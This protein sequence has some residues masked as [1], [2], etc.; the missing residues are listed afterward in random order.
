MSQSGETGVAWVDVVDNP[1]I[2]FTTL[3]VP[4]PTGELLLNDDA[5]GAPSTEPSVIATTNW[6]NLVAFRDQRSDGGDIYLQSVNNA[7]LLDEVNQRVDQDS[8]SA[9]QSEPSLAVSGSQALIVWVDS[10]DMPGQSGQRVLGRFSSLGGQMSGDEFAISESGQLAVKRSPVAVMNVSGFGLVVWLDERGGLAQVYGK[11]LD[12]NGVPSGTELLFSNPAVDLQIVDLRVDIDG[13]DN[14]YLLWLDSGGASSVVRM[15]SFRPDHSALSSFDWSPPL[16]GVSLLEATARVMTSEEVMVAWIGSDGFSRNLYLSQLSVTGTELTAP[17]LIDDNAN[18]AP[19]RPRLSVS[20][21]NYCALTWID[22][23]EGRPLL[24]YQV[25]NASLAPLLANQPVAAT[26]VEFMISPAIYASDGRAWFS[27]VDNRSNGLNVQASVVIYEPTDVDE[28][29]GVTLPED[30]RLAQ[31]YP[32]P[33]NPSTVIEYSL[34][35]RSHVRLEIFDLLGK[36]VHLLVDRWQP[37]GEYSI[38]WD[39]LSAAGEK[40]ASGVYFYRM[41]TGDFSSRRK[42]ILLK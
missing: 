42:M 21:N 11:W 18:A 28:G 12:M 33:F 20:N 37:A 40:V 34:P 14:V 23:R 41:T 24:Y 17:V 6:R 31:N 39:G 9:V 38:S 4:P 2:H 25:L 26:A 32:N 35:Q 13:S 15:R 36:R 30:F 16:I 1:D 29:D 10:R 19:S 3:S 7:G 27:W 22:H 8:G 5:I